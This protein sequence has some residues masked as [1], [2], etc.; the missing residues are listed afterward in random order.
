[1]Q[2]FYM[3]DLK[4]GFYVKFHS[5]CRFPMS[6]IAR[7]GQNMSIS[8]DLHGLQVFYKGFYKGFLQG[9]YGLYKVT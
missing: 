8:K 1:M 9:L 4:F 7:L 5:H 2:E 6:K 3:L